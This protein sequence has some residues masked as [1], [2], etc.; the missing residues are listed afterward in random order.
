[1]RP[2]PPTRLP[3]PSPKLSRKLS[4][5]LR[6]RSRSRQRPNSSQNPSPSLNLSNHRSMMPPIPRQNRRPPRQCR[7][8]AWKSSSR[9]PPTTFQKPSSSPWMRPSP[10]C[11]ISPSPLPRRRQQRNRTRRSGATRT[12]PRPQR[13]RRRSTST[14]PIPR[15][16]KPSALSWTRTTPTP[17]A[18]IRLWMTRRPRNTPWIWTIPWTTTPGTP[19]MRPGQGAH[20]CRRRR[21]NPCSRFLRPRRSIFPTADGPTAR[22]WWGAR[23][24][25]PRAPRAAMPLP[26][27]PRPRNPGC[28][29]PPPEQADTRSK[30]RPQARASAPD[31]AG[32]RRR[33]ARVNAEGLSVFINETARQLPLSN[34]S[35]HGLAAYHEG[36]AFAVEQVISLDLMTS[37]KVL[38]KD[39]Q[40]RVI[41]CDATLMACKFINLDRQS[42]VMLRAIVKRLQQIRSRQAAGGS[43]P[44][45]T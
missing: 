28:S 26:R 10:S 43:P 41:R 27:R 3:R 7:W 37:Y 22:R 29:R 15:R 33:T 5:S 21:L 19:N 4:R 12:M 30:P 18:W 34:L 17:R 16:V 14:G 36:W 35:E 8:M 1:M 32:D 11:W 2:Q 13:Q 42:L 24:T 20:P 44:G 25:T 39:L 40:C 45:A 9:R 6:P 23:G 31:T 38:M